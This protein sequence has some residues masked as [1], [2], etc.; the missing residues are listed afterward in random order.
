MTASIV[1]KERTVL[2]MAGGTGGH[3]FPALAVAQELMKRNY[4]LHWLGAKN[5]MEETLVPKNHIELS[6]I[7]ISGIRG[8]GRLTL[9]GAPARILIAVFQA[10][11]ILRAQKPDCVLGFG[12]FASGPGGIA[13]WLSGIPLVIHEQNAIAGMTNRLL[14]PLA[15]KVL[16]AFPNAFGQEKGVIVTG[17][18]LRRA[19][20]EG[21]PSSHERPEIEQNAVLNLLVLGGSLGAAT[22]NRV[23][24]EAV[25]CL[26]V[27]RRPVI[28]HQCGQ[29][30][31]EEARSAYLAKE[32]EAE[33]VP[34]IDNMRAAYDW[35]DL[36][37]CRAGA[38][39]VAE[40]AASGK[41]ALFVPYPFAVDDHQSANAAY[42]ANA[43]GAKVLPEQSLSS[44]ELAELLQRL[45]ENRAEL[46]DM[47]E[48]AR[49]QARP[50]AT[51]VVADICEEVMNG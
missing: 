49:K 16:C 27:S 22:L 29:R 14:K 32:V 8:K 18:P 35:A 9:L 43:G 25:A 7:S 2:V 13:A 15:R 41:A 31:L 3:I 37:I 38:M 17:N 51:R 40:L 30:K 12:G 6:L 50:E 23:I 44:S 10:W 33:V 11:R 28:R 39:T 4:R 26:P 42:L 45:T 46:S 34:F 47:A 5:G 21:H 19:F 20:Y 36:V 1:N 48:R 24:P